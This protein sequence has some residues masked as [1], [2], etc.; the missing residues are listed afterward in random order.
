VN[1]IEQIRSGAVQFRAAG[2]EDV[3]D[4]EI[5]VRAVPYSEEYTD[6]GGIMERFMPGAFSAVTSAPHRVSIFHDHGGPLV[7]RATEV[8]DKAD[9]VYVRAK[10]SRT[11]AAEEF[12]MLIADGVLRDM[13][14][15][16]R[17][18]RDSMKVSQKGDALYVTHHKAHLTG[19]AAVPE[20]AYS[21]QTP[22]LSA[23]D[24]KSAK[25]VEEAR[26]WLEAYRN[27][28]FTA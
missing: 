12:L 23:R 19:V 15:E 10:I 5:Y 6:I 17:A 1:R 18:D 24:L 27:R 22:I 9:A 7:G 28:S 14:V 2:I 16:F 26:A 20:A 11:P 3:A 25:E 21:G 8:E 13:S 4:H